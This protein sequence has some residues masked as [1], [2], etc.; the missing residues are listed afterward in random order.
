MRNIP[1][2]DISAMQSFEEVYKLCRKKNI[3]VLFSH[4]NEQPMSVIEKSGF[5]EMVGE[6]NFLK[7]IDEALMCAEKICNE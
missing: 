3:R 5:Y 1:A 4:V 2:L 6:E 7:N